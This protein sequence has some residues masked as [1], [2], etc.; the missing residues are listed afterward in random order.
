MT[1]LAAEKNS[2]HR[3]E[4]QEK[5]AFNAACS[6]EYRGSLQAAGG[7]HLW[8]FFIGKLCKESVFSATQT[9]PQRLEG[10]QGCVARQAAAVPREAMSQGYKGSSWE[11]NATGVGQPGPMGPAGIP[12]TLSS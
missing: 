3:E 6:G 7:N 4:D 11:Q 12:Q 9:L 5:L 8:R 2:L 10:G 1:V